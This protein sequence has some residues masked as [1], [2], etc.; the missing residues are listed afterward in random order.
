[1]EM[2]LYSVTS[3]QI[4]VVNLQKHLVLPDFDGFKRKPLS[5]YMATMTKYEDGL[6]VH[7]VY[8]NQV[9]LVPL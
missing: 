3:A 7:I 9:T 5:I 4:V 8:Q 6:P 2:R 1:M